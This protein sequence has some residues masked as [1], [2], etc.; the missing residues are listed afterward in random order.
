MLK[1]LNTVGE[2]PVHRRRKVLMKASE[3]IPSIQSF[4]QDAT[5]TPPPAFI[6]RLAEWDEKRREKVCL[7]PS[8][9]LQTLWHRSK[10]SGVA[11]L[12]YTLRCIAVMTLHV[13]A[14]CCNFV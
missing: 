4:V 3:S 14:L 9:M 8:G 2:G 10:H 7:K 6:D 12:D 11:N 13:T 1:E 5:Q